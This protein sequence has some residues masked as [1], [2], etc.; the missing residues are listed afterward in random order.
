MTTRRTGGAAPLFSILLPSRN[1]LPLLRHAIASIEAQAGADVEIIV[2]DNASDE[3]YVGYVAK[4]P[5][6]RIVYA[7]CDTPISVTA[8]WNRAVA[9]A[10]GDY[11]IMLGDDDALAPNLLAKLRDLIRRFDD[12]DVLYLKAYHYAYPGVFGPSHPGYL[13]EVGNSPLFEMSTQPFLLDRALGR[14]LARNAFRFRHDISFNAQHYVWRRDFIRQVA[15]PDGFFQSPYPDYYAS[16]V[17]FLSAPRIVVV[18]SPL[19]MIGISKSSFGFFYFNNRADEGANA[20]LTESSID[21]GPA[22]KDPAVSAALRL[23]GSVHYRNWLLAMLYARRDLPGEPDLAVGLSRY[24]RLQLLDLT[25]RTAF[26]KELDRHAWLGQLAAAA[27]RDWWT[28]RALLW[29]FAMLA[30]A[31]LLPPGA[32]E[33]LVR[34]LADVYHPVIPLFLDI[35]QHDTIVDAYHWLEEVAKNQHEGT[36]P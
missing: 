36:S 28:A 25:Y 19:I 26:R 16:V 22:P 13:C 20:F 21:L 29:L 32:V 11:I 23:P 3:D 17:T 9:I 6:I 12:P 2:A 24:R 14:R 15:H 30:R 31:P 33:R 18:P 10:R 27:R 5:E 4:V 8:N 7:R 34:R 35:G 1:R